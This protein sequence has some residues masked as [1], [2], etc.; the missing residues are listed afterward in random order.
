MTH[1]SKLESRVIRAFVQGEHAAFRKI[2]DKYYLVVYRAAFAIVLNRADTD[3]IVQET[4]M[5]A[6]RKCSK[7]EVSKSL[8]GWLRTIA[9][10]KAIDLTRRKSLRRARPLEDVDHFIS[11]DPKIVPEPSKKLIRSLEALPTEPRLML[12]MFEV[13]GMSGQEIAGLLDCSLEKVKTALHRARKKLR[14]LYL[15]AAPEERP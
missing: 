15:K 7:F 1:D 11:D 9:F 14:D 2:F 13:H 4:F 10:R 5:Q 8:G 3:D 6:F 12:I